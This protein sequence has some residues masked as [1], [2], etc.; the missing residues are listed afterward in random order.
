M[1]VAASHRCC[2]S[3]GSSRGGDAAIAAF[4]EG[5]DGTERERALPGSLSREETLLTAFILR[6]RSLPARARQRTA[7]EGVV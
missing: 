3:A 4:R 1:Y 6:A 5:M 7:D 2:C